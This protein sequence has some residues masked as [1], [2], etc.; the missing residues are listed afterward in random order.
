[1]GKNLLLTTIC[2]RIIVDF[3]VAVVQQTG[4][5]RE[6]IHCAREMAR[7]SLSGPRSGRRWLPESRRVQLGGH[8][9]LV[10]WFLFVGDYHV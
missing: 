4:H 5:V 10:H 1:M 7:T 2:S 9:L 8:I 3:V 6:P